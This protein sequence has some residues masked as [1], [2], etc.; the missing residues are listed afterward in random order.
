[1]RA[2][3]TGASGHIATHLIR[4]LLRE[5]HSVRALVRAGSNVSA[6]SSLDVELYRGDVLDS[7]SL[8][9]AMANCETVFHLAAPT[10]DVSDIGD[11]IVNGTRNVLN[12]AADSGVSTIVYTSSIV[13][14]GYS[15]SPDQILDESNSAQ[16]SATR[17]HDA[18]FLAEKLALEWAKQ[19]ICRLVVVNPSTVVGSLDMR[20]TPSNE[21]IERAIRKGLRFTFD[22]GLTIAPVQDVARGHLLAFQKGRTG[23]RYILGGEQLVIKEYFKLVEECCGSQRRQ[24]HLPRTA[25]LGIGAGFSAAKLVTR[26]QVPFTFTQ[27]RSLAG[28][29]GFYSSR[30]A[31]EELGYQWRSAKEAITDFVAW[32]RAGRP[33]TYES[34]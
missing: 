1:M 32:V 22:S 11:I 4:V 24:F 2:L 8:R 20:V 30:K 31:E 18:K 27:A 5:G 10:R 33:V 26:R 15:E 16:S 25:L 29:Y 12:T 21:V 28:K 3:V 7:A 34:R 13:T 9:S 6:I 14:V 19:G 23:E 17:Y